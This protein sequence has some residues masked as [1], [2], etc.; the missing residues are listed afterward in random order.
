MHK[1][2]LLILSPNFLKLTSEEVDINCIFSSNNLL[3]IMTESH[4]FVHHTKNN[5]LHG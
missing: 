2:E 1:C 5:S 3:E 4:S